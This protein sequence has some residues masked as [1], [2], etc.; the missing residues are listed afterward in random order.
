M[1]MKSA[2]HQFLRR[3]SL[4]RQR[5]VATPAQMMPAVRTIRHHASESN[6]QW[7][8][9]SP[10]SIGSPPQRARQT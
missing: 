9:K 3:S 7:E 10:R 1:G 5:S 4:L 2:F 6:P 8:T